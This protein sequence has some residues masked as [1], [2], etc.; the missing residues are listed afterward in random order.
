[1]MSSKNKD[2]SDNKIH[3]VVLDDFM[4]A[5]FP[6]TQGLYKAVLGDDIILGKEDDELPIVFLNW[7]CMVEFCNLL[8]ERL[9]LL[10][11]YLIDKKNKDPNNLEDDILDKS[12]W[13]IKIYRDSNDFK[14]QT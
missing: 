8:S 3:E 4:M 10:H 9:G 1:M 7:Y 14:L 5:K 2:R 6:V 12:K 11:Y 13:T